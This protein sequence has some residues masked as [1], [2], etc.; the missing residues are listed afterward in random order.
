MIDHK[1]KITNI[2]HNTFKKVTRVMHSQIRNAVF[3][4]IATIF[5]L[6]SLIL[7]MRHL[8]AHRYH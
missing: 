6:T 2:V 8:M 4:D 7:P 5:T 1:M 3:R